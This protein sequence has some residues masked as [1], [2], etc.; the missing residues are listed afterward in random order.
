MAKQGWFDSSSAGWAEALALADDMATANCFGTIEKARI[1]E[2][3]A[4]MLADS[5]LSGRDRG[6]YLASLKKM[7]HEG[8]KRS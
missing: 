1:A 2:M 6:I 8:I 4:R 5:R 3:A 7:F